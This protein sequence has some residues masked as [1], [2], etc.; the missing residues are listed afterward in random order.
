MNLS[1][2][3][4]SLLFLGLSAAAALCHAQEE[5]PISLT[6]ESVSV[7]MGGASAYDSYLSPLKY[8]GWNIS[9]MSEQLKN[10]RLWNGRVVSQHLLN[11][12]FADMENPPGSTTSY[13][14]YLEYDYGLYYR[15]N[16]IQKLR[17]FAGLQGDFLL[18]ILHNAR[19]SNNPVNAKGDVN[20][21]LSAMATYPFQIKKQPIWLRYQ[22]SASLV[23]AMFSP[24]FG[25][26]Y[27]EIGLGQGASP[28]HF[29]AWHNRLALRNMLSVEIPFNSFTLRITG[30]NWLYQSHVNDLQTQIVTNS[31]QLGL[32]KYFHVVSVK[33]PDKNKYRY[34]FE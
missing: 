7:G 17:I 34:V 19:N 12:E 21:N 31:L 27:Y 25:Q 8:S 28:V 26:S 23:G 33:K 16:P 24:E 32:S 13:L 9:L 11:L 4:L 29:T 18:G 3:K 5:A 1:L 2:K 22:I 15:F 30:M 6:Y 20:L 14:G 10:T